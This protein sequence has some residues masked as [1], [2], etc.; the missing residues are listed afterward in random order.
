VNAV[1][2]LAGLGAFTFTDAAI[3]AGAT[4]VRA[5]HVSELRSALGAALSA[6]ALPVPAFS[7]GVAVGSRVNAV[8]VNELRSAVR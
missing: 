7:P 1:R 5:V 6:L 4:T 3:T 8:H 2:T